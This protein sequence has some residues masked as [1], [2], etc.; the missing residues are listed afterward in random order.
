MWAKKPLASNVKLPWS[1][2]IPLPPWSG[3]VAFPDT[4]PCNMSIMPVNVQFLHCTLYPSGLKSTS[5][6]Q[7]T[8]RKKAAKLTQREH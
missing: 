5:E 3:F 2:E 1:K 4:E 6:S 7:A 8:A